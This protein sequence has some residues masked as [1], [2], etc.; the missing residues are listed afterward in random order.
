MLGRSSG[1]DVRLVTD[2]SVSRRHC[3]VALDGSGAWVQD[4]GS[5]NGTLVNG[6]N[7]GRRSPGRGDDSTIP[8]LSRHPLCDGDELRLCNNVFAVVL[9]DEETPSR[10]GEASAEATSPGR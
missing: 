10:R 9:A 4:L 7:I 2:A 6:Q 8:E 3:L 5:R 1:C